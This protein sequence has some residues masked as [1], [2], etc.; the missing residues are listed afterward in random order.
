LGYFGVFDVLMTYPK[1][2][3]KEKT[4]EITPFDESYGVDDARATK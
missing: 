1:K 2:K 4:H 3:K